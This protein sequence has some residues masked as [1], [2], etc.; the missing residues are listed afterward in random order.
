M[1]RLPCRSVLSRSL[2]LFAAAA[3]LTA[4]A[5]APRRPWFDDY[6]AL[7]AAME[8]RYANLGWYASPAGGF[9]RPGLDRRALAALHRAGNVDEARDAIRAFVAAFDDGHFSVV[10]SVANEPA[11]AEAEPPRPALDEADARQG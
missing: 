4:A 1:S 6:A 7:K 8:A 2:L 3:G 9:D 10:Q 5:P 11:P